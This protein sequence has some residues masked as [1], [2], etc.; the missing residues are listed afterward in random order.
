MDKQEAL[1]RAAA[2]CSTGEHSEKE[3]YDKCIKWGCTKDEA[4]S[5]VTRLVKER[6]IDSQRF[7]RAFVHDKVLYDH[8]GRQKIRQG[9]F[10]KGI[11]EDIVQEALCMIDNELAD[12]Y[13]GNLQSAILAKH[14]QLGPEPNEEDYRACQSYRQKIM[15][16]LASRGYTSSEIFDNL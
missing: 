13:I 2:Q 6:F 1:S 16:H 5:I 11:N 8:W 10:I 4:I 12:E 15:R 7:A 14:R 3:I 9:L